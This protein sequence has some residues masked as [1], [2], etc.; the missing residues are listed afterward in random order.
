[1]RYA[2]NFLPLSVRGQIFL[3]EEM[4]IVFEV[5]SLIVIFQILVIRA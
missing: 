5:R 3:G 2:G 4:R 1:M